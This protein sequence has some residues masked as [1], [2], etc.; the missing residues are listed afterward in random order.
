M[1]TLFLIS[2]FVLWALVIPLTILNL[3]LF[4]QMGILIMGTAR[5]IHDSGVPIGKKLPYFEGVSVDGLKWNINKEMGSP[6]LFLFVSPTCSECKKILP[7]FIN[8][9]SKYSV[10]PVLFIFSD[11]EEAKDYISKLNYKGRAIVLNSAQGAAIDVS[12]TPFAYAINSQGVVEEKGLV[13]TYGHIEK[14]VTSVAQKV[15]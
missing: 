6:S 2:Y 10:D 12:A 4:R 11:I 14:Y 9:T 13:N 7:D 3:I 15:A 1:S 5:G 8:I